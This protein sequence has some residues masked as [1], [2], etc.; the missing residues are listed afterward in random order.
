MGSP[1]SGRGAFSAHSIGTKASSVH[2]SFVVAMG[3]PSG[4]S[5]VF[6]P[7]DRNEVVFG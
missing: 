6:L 7:L 1:I 2:H 4:S 5:V 3:S